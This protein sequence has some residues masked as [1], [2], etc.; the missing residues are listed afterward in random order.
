MR[1][2]ELLEERELFISF[3]AAKD[4]AYG[5]IGPT[6]PPKDYLLLLIFIAQKAAM[7]AAAMHAVAAMRER[8]WI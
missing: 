1:L 8:G 5:M 2:D 4:L 6:E 3:E 7:A